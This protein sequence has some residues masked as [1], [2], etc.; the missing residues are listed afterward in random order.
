MSTNKSPPT[1]RGVDMANAF[2]QVF[3]NNHGDSNKM[4]YDPDAILYYTLFNMDYII[5]MNDFK[6]FISNNYAVIIDYLSNQ[7][8]DEYKATD[9]FKDK[10]KHWNKCDSSEI[11]YALSS[12]S[13]L[14]L[15]TL[16][17]SKDTIV[18]KDIIVWNINIEDTDVVDSYSE[19][20]HSNVGNSG[21]PCDPT[22][23]SEPYFP[24]E[25]CVINFDGIKSS[26]KID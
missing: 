9:Y 11:I 2:V 6:K 26:T 7:Y 1:Q 15:H 16:H 14:C 25:Y 13:P 10:L 4:V 23:A 8:C 18:D 20:D 3:K 12:N 21:E 19:Y 24:E 17:F 5:T 22:E